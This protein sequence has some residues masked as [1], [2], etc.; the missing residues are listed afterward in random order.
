[1]EKGKFF[2]LE[3]IDGCGKSTQ[4]PL[5]AGRLRE[6]GLPVYET[7]EPTDSPIGELIRRFL[8]G[9]AKSD[10]RVLA[11]LFAADRLGHLLNGPDSL[12][13]KVD[14][15]VTVVSDR[16]YFSSYAYNSVD[17]P[18][19]WVIGANSLCADMLRPTLTVFIDIEPEEAIRRIERGRSDFELFEKLDRLALV[20][21]SYFEA[22]EKLRAVENVAVVDGSKSPEAVA[23]QIWALFGKSF[24]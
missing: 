11:G 9:E 5:L 19:E 15:G 6:R 21:K 1:M 3:G 22:F 17:A 12:L 14:G 24:S 4:A 18:M 10:N 13:E 23:E 16:Y 7:N 2:V 8:T 20:R